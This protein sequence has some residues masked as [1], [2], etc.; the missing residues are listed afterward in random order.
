MAM[1]N[2]KRLVCRQKTP[3]AAKL[4]VSFLGCWIPFRPKTVKHPSKSAEPRSRR[5]PLAPKSP[6]EPDA[7]GKTGHR[8]RGPECELN[9]EV[10]PARAET[11]AGLASMPTRGSRIAGTK[12]MPGG[13]GRASDVQQKRRTAQDAP[14]RSSRVPIGIQLRNH[15]ASDRWLHLERHA[16]I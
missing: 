4:Q 15:D 1:L 2:L 10:E 13:L 12:G 7:R 14:A 11:R 8:V 5:V 6:R 9:I 16:V 3:D